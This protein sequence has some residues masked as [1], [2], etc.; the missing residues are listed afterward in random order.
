M[1]SSQPDLQSMFQGVTQRN[2]VERKKERERERER[3]GGMDRKQKGVLVS[4]GKFSTQIFVRPP[5]YKTPLQV[6][7]TSDY[8][9]SVLQQKCPKHKGCWC[10]LA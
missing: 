7:M 2:L 3:E 10:N 8:Y 6:V 1:S 5:H 4:R 9:L